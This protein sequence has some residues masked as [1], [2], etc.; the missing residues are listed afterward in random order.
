MNAIVDRLQ[1]RLGK[2]CLPK[3]S[4][5]AFIDEIR[6]YSEEVERELGALTSSRTQ[7]LGIIN[8][9]PVA[10]FV[11]DHESRFILM[12]HACEEQWGLSF[13]Q[14][15]NGLNKLI[16]LS[17]RTDGAVSGQG[18]GHFRGPHTS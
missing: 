8:L 7:L 5:D 6:V 10:F 17:A 4:C 14:L 13:A 15:Q 2:E 11:K 12:N 1:L 9:I 16:F 3:A 18:S